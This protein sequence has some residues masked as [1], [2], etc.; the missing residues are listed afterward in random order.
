M[1]TDLYAYDP[2]YSYDYGGMFFGFFFAG[3]WQRTRLS[4]QSIYKRSAYETRK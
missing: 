2:Y 4:I 1:A 3:T